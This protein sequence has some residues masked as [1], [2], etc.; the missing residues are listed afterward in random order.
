MNEEINAYIEYL[1][2][3]S[4][5]HKPIMPKFNVLAYTDNEYTSAIYNIMKDYS[6]V[7]DE[8]LT[9]EHLKQ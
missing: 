4:M 8:Y 3:F 2:N 9:I 6:M 7:E 1:L 5:V